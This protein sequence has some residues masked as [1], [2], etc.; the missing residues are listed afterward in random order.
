[1]GDIIPPIL[2]E[3]AVEWAWGLTHSF[4]TSKE[5]KGIGESISLDIRSRMKR[6][7]D[8]V[9]AEENTGRESDLV[10]VNAV[11]AAVDSTARNLGIII[12]GRN[13]NFKGVDDL[14]DARQDN[15]KAAERLSKDA[16]SYVPRLFAAG[17]GLSAPFVLLEFFGITLPAAVVVALGVIAAGVAYLLFQ[18]LVAPRRRTAA[19]KVLID[20][21][22]QR[23][24][25]Y[26]QYLSSSRSALQSLLENVLHFHRRVYGLVYDSRYND[27]NNVKGFVAG[28]M[29]GPHADPKRCPHI[30][31]HYHERI[32]TPVLWPSCDSGEGAEKCPFYY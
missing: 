29:G 12:A 9:E 17:G 13:L 20:A 8:E 11:M 10:Y 28:V 31:E 27:L 23:N 3:T 6:I 21:D 30:D 4:S 25:Y 2:P 7:R 32:I 14:R 1:M 19:Q 18:V 5:G 22:Y 16:Q 15:V 24:V 26:S